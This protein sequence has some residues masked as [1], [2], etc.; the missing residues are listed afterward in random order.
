MHQILFETPPNKPSERRP[1]ILG[2][3]ISPLKEDNISYEIKTG[4]ARNYM[5]S[6]SYTMPNLVEA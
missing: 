1:H 4:L 3:E 5:A 6:Q 2:D